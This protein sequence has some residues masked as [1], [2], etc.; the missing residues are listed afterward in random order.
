MRLTVFN[1]SPRVNKGNTALML[2]PFLAGFTEQGGEAHGPHYLAQAARR[3]RHAEA[4]A[5][6]DVALIAFPLYVDAMP[7]TVKAFTEALAPYLGRSCNPRVM[8]LVQSGFPEACH[9]RPIEAW[10]EKFARRMG[11]PYMG[12]IIKGSGEGLRQQPAMVR[13]ALFR[14][15]HALGQSLQRTGE[16]D[17]RL[18]ASLAGRD[19]Y[20]RLPL[21]LFAPLMMRLGMGW[22]NRQLKANGVFERRDAAPYGVSASND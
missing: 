4:F 13:N 2:E 10:L 14:N 6:A 21:T 9:S 18:L 11:S 19:H 3:P 8:F 7:A 12:T 1:G 15:L 5:A 17:P 20:S 16:L 22:W